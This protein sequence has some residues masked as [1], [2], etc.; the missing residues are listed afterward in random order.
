MEAVRILYPNH[1]HP[2]HLW[3]TLKRRV[4]RVHQCLSALSGLLLV[5]SLTPPKV[6]EV[7]EWL[8][9]EAVLCELRKLGQAQLPQLSIPLGFHLPP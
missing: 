7:R 5:L 3:R 4:T 1:P 2:E 9:S 8:S 6:V